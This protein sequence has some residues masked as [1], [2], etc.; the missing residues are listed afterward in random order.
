ME[1]RIGRY[2]VLEEISSSGHATVYR[3]RD[4]RSGEVLALKVLHPHLS[5]DSSYLERFQREARM[6]SSLHHP[7]V[8]RIFEVGQ[9]GDSYFIAMEYLPLSLNHLLRVQGRLPV[10]QAVAIAHLV[11][12]GLEAAQREGIVHRDVKP[13]NILMEPEGAVKITDFGIARAQDLST[14]THTGMVMGTP[15][16]MPPEQARGL[17]PD[18]R[19]DLYSLGVVL[20]QMLTGQ[21]PFGGDTPWEVIRR[22][23]EERLTP[24]HEAHPEIPQDVASVVERCLHKE[25]AERYQTPLEMTQALEGLNL[26]LPQTLSFDPAMATAGGGSGEPPVAATLP[27][28]TPPA[29]WRRFLADPRRR[30]LLA[31]AGVAATALLV[32]FPAGGLD[33]LQDLFD[34]GDGPGPIVDTTPTPT[35]TPSPTVM[36]PTAT[37]PPTSTPVPSPTATPPLP[38]PDPSNVVKPVELIPEGETVLVRLTAAEAAR[39][40]I[41][42]VGI[43]ARRDISGA[44]LAVQRLTQRPTETLPPG[45]VFSYLDI[46]LRDTSEANVDA[47]TITF[48][49]PVS[50]P[51]ENQV[52]PG[53]IALYWYPGEWEELPTSMVSEEAQALTFTAQ[54]SGFSF[55]AIAGQNAPPTP[56]P[57]PRPTPTPAPIGNE[58]VFQH[59]AIGEGE[60]PSFT[61]SSSPWKLQY[62]T[63]WTGEFDLRVGGGQGFRSLAGRSVTAGV[64]Y[65]T[66]V[67]DW[68]GSMQ[69]IAENVPPGGEWSVVVI[70]NPVVSPV[71]SNFNPPETIFVYTGTGE[72]NSPPFEVGSS[73]WKLLYTTSWSGPFTLQA[74]GGQG[75]Q[76]VTGENV[77]AGVVYESFIYN[78]T[79]PM[80]FS[81]VDT[82]ADQQWTVWVVENPAIPTVSSSA[83]AAGILFT[84][85]GTGEINSPP[86]EVE[87][88]PWRLL[89]TTSW[90]GSFTLQATGGDG[91]QAL[92]DQEVQAG[93]L[94]ET[95]IS[96][97]TGFLYLS[98]AGAPSDGA[99]SVSIVKSE[100]PS[101]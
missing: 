27:L 79:G 13:Q 39:V 90:T 1:K 99:W 20:Y 97:L 88:S 26:P 21:L 43:S 31:F 96:D 33:G 76:P 23:V 75:F 69:F 41:S 58:T 101:E 22:H 9:E 54:A 3:V 70:G 46:S 14:M 7:N 57:T 51:Q 85:T 19:S 93:V 77:T 53:S 48:L 64:L 62:L 95:L 82:P 10:D 68:T 11:C 87:S 34:S 73:P 52:S 45:E 86:F 28:P 40:G 44:T 4:T 42:E 80:H 91:V 71:E 67:Y 74:G 47:A 5:R 49:V 55:F 92:V 63:S 2:R 56:T 37:P 25:P 17:Q 16:Y 50:W 15:Q 36:P 65:E 24:L 32:L 81:A 59:Q 6:A 94:N 83:A 30:G 100:Q 89:Y 60:S 72:V 66:F 61:V 78:W 12:Q 8:V 29:G 38:T 35:A 18:V 98:A 84:H